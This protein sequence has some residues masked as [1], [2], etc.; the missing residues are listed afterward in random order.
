MSYVTPGEYLSGLQIPVPEY[1]LKSREGAAVRHPSHGVSVPCL[2]KQSPFGDATGQATPTATQLR[3]VYWYVVGSIDDWDLATDQSQ[4][5][6]RNA[7]ARDRE[8]R[9]QWLA[10]IGSANPGLSTDKL[11]EKAWTAASM[12]SRRGT[13][14]SGR[15]SSK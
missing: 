5:T 2:V 14:R 7:F 6:L 15:Y 13:R 12:T 3:R 4:T 8:I 1:L 9:D 10:T 11:E